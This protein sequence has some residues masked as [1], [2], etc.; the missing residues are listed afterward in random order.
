MGQFVL[1]WDPDFP[2]VRGRGS[3]GKS[4]PLWTPYIS[5]QWLNIETSNTVGILGGGDPNENY[6]KVTHRNWGRAK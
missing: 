2:T 4:G 5:K 1:D 3:S 6:S